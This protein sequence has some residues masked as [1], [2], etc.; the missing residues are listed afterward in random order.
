[1]HGYLH[2]S[3]SR[4]MMLGACFTCLVASIISG[5]AGPLWLAQL[6]TALD[7]FPCWNDS[8]CLQMPGNVVVMGSKPAA[9]FR[10]HCHSVKFYCVNRCRRFTLIILAVSQILQSMTALLTLRHQN[11]Q[12]RPCSHHS[13]IL[14]QAMLP[15]SSTSW[16]F[17][18]QLA[19]PCLYNTVSSSQQHSLCS[20][21]HSAFSLIKTSCFSPFL[22]LPRSA[23]KRCNRIAP[24]SDYTLT[25][26]SVK[27]CRYSII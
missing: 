3:L 11:V 13:H 4:C 1:M 15:H 16:S 21:L 19:P 10:L 23:H 2:L 5:L 18:K 6:N 17:L 22:V 27:V 12:A 7:F 20:L 26:R 9:G 24:L 25:N 14:A 8:T